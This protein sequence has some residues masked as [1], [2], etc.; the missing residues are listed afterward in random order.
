MPSGFIALSGKPD[1]CGY[2]RFTLTGAMSATA[3]V[4]RSVFSSAR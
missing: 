2:V 1:A 4:S 3:K